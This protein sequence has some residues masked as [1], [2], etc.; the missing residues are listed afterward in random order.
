MILPAAMPNGFLKLVQVV[1]DNGP[2]LVPVALG[3]IGIYLLLPRPRQARPAFGAI[4]AGL[5]ILL[6]GAF[7]VH[8]E[9]V[10]PE[11]ILFYMFA[12]IA[13]VGGT[14]LINLR[15]PVHAALSFALVVVRTCGL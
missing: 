4:L 10:L 12:G 14:L 8:V 11:K 2:L 9:A 1:Q 7:A 5:A 15:N 3:F 13:I 6:G